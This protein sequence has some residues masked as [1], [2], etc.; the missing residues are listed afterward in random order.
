MC[1]FVTQFC[2]LLPLAFK[3]NLYWNFEILYFW[4][5]HG[6]S[7][8]LSYGPATGGGLTLSPLVP[9]LHFIHL[10][11]VQKSS[12]FAFNSFI[13]FVFSRK[14]ER[15]TSVLEKEKFGRLQWSSSVG[16]KRLTLFRMGFFGAAPA[17]LKSATHILQWWNL[18]QLYLT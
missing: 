12:V 18:A 3:E 9:Q 2:F 14:L 7:W 6:H 10:R 15:H 8:G 4:R 16:G 17:S 11:C 1:T 5:Y 13:S